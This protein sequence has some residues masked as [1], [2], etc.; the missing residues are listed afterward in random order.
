M[1]VRLAVQN[2]E[3]SSTEQS[4]NAE[5]ALPARSNRPCCVREIAQLG[6]NQTIAGGVAAEEPAVIVQ[7]IELSSVQDIE[8]G[9]VQEVYK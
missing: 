4:G 5:G 6:G 2:S 7:D 9:S 1:L 8:L 3:S